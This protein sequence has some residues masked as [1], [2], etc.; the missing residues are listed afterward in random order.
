METSIFL[1]VFFWVLI[2]IIVLGIGLLIIFELSW[3]NIV[4]N[5]GKLC[6]TGSCE[7]TTEKCGSTPFKMVNGSPSCAPS[8]I[9]QGK[10]PRTTTS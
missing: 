4:S 7:G 10:I 5:E 8:S 2:V 6:L 1:K 9:F 3:R